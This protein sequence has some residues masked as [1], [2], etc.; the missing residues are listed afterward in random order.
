MG[1]RRTGLCLLA[2]FVLLVP[3]LLCACAQ[4]TPQYTLDGRILALPEESRRVDLLGLAGDT[5]ADE[6]PLLVERVRLPYPVNVELADGRVLKRD[7]MWRITVR[8]KPGAFPARALPWVVWIGE[9]RLMAFESMDLSSLVAVSFE[10]ELISPGMTVSVSY[11]MMGG[12]R[13]LVAT[14]PDSQ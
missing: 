13:A 10:R 6:L 8:E 2:K 12:R 9:T 7:S 1:S 3:S 4:P 11:G 5:I 14:I